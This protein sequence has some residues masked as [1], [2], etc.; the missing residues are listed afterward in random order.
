VLV[1]MFLLE[2]VEVFRYSLAIVFSKSRTV[3]VR[4]HRRGYIFA[5]SSG[6]FVEEALKIH[7][8]ALNSH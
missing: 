1:V 4:K 6:Q 2:L 8:S 3:V 5:L 7:Q